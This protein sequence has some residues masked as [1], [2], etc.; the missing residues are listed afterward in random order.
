MRKTG[1]GFNAYRI[2][3]SNSLSWGSGLELRKLNETFKL[4]S[5]QKHFMIDAQVLNE[6]GVLG[7]VAAAIAEA[8]S[9]ILNVHLE[10]EGSNLSVIHFKLQVHD[11]RHLAAVM[12]AMR[13]I[14]QVARVVRARQARPGR[15]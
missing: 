6:R 5:V 8:D 2:R 9:N 10:D 11:R 7:R 14:H 3:T 15:P 1:A 12:R 4:A 13:R